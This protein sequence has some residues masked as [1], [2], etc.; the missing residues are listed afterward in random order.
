MAVLARYFCLCD[1]LAKNK[2]LYPKQ[3]GFQTRDSTE[4]AIVQFVNQI[5]ESFERN[6]YTLDV[7]INLSKAV[8]TLNTSSKLELNGATLRKRSRLKNYLSNK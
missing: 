8:D 4:H 1:Y 5:L 3:F 7:F 6:K 2:L